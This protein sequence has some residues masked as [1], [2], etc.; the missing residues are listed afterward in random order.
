M[1]G[2]L[3][4]LAWLFMILFVLQ[5]FYYVSLINQKLSWAEKCA[6]FAKRIIAGFIGLAAVSA[7]RDVSNYLTNL[8]LAIP[9]TSG[10]GP[11]LNTLAGYST[12]LAVL[13]LIVFR[14]ML[15]GILMLIVWLVSKIIAK[16][17]I[18][19][20]THDEVTVEEPNSEDN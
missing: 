3:R 8:K 6:L 12:I 5:G 13:F 11:V 7:I 2:F 17:K 1:I 20:E 16:R 4:L 14:F 19:L 9:D 18:K 15:Y 10:L